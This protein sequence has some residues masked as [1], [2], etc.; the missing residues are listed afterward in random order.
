MIRG[1]AKVRPFLLHVLVPLQA[2][3]GI[4]GLSISAKQTAIPKTQPARRIPP[5]VST[6][7]VSE[8][9]AAL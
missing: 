2:M 7:P 5:G 1:K 3:A 4:G 6:S 9:D 8:A